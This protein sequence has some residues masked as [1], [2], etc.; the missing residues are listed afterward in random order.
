MRIR[1]LNE[2]ALKVSTDPELA[3]AISESPVETISSLAAPLQTDVWIYRIVVSA[4]GLVI[5][6][7]IVGGIVLGA[8]GKGTPELL[9]AIGSASVGALAGLLAP[10]PGSNSP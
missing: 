5:I 4:L 3:K 2:L 9:T 7:A 1:S 8:L 6:L 10:Q